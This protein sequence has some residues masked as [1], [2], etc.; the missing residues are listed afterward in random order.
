MVP[1]ARL[2]SLTL[3]SFTFSTSLAI[4]QG[5]KGLKISD[6]EIRTTS[7]ATCAKWFKYLIHAPSVL[8]ERD[9]QGVVSLDRERTALAL[10]DMAVANC[11]NTTTPLSGEELPRWRS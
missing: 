10:L 2:Q 9:D 11:S 1:R 5:T 3:S 7:F 4:E 8:A 6:H